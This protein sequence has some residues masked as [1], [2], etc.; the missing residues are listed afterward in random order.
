M[1]CL[2]MICLFLTGC[3]PQ[4]HYAFQ[5]FSTPNEGTILSVQ[6]YLVKSSGVAEFEK[7]WNIDY[8]IPTTEAKIME[9]MNIDIDNG[10][11]RSEITVDRKDNK[12]AHLK[13]NC[14]NVDNINY[15][16]MTIVFFC[17]DETL[18]SKM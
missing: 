3:G 17:Y 13:S 14:L 4:H 16:I 9:L 12:L 2:G 18:N 11:V 6:G 10:Q 1:A 5:Q 15:F 8:Q 7:N